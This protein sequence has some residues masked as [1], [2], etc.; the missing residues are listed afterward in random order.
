MG[1]TCACDCTRA[2]GVNE[3]SSQL[4]TE[5]FDDSDVYE[6]LKKA[7]L[8]IV[9]RDDEDL[10]ERDYFLELMNFGGKTNKKLVRELN[11]AA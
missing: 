9:K 3:I 2:A 6:K 4:D 5:P 11:R 7:N 1:A 8:H 10:I